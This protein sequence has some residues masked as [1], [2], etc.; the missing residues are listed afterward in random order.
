MLEISTQYFGGRGGGGGSAGKENSILKNSVFPAGTY[1]SGDGDEFQIGY[2]TE[3]GHN[4]YQTSDGRV[5]SDAHVQVM[6][7]GEDKGKYRAYNEDG[8]L[9][10][11]GSAEEASKWAF[12]SPSDCDLKKKKG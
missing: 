4:I 1:V 10:T 6:V 5:V 8:R 12:G 2:T 11:T 3:S 7:E 9:K